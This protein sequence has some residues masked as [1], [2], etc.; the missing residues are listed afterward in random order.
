MWSMALCGVR[1]ICI[2]EIVAGFDVLVHRDKLWNAR[3]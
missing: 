3:M 2:G 1:V